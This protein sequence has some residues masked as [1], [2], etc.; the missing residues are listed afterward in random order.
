M[1][2]SIG[3][4][5][6]SSFAN[7]TTTDANGVPHS[8]SSFSEN[9]D[10]TFVETMQNNHKKRLVG[11]ME[12]NNSLLEE[13]NREIAE[14]QQQLQSQHDDAL[15]REAL[16]RAEFQN[17]RQLHADQM[18]DQQLIF[19]Q[20]REKQMEIEAELKE[21]YESSIELLKK[22]HEEQLLAIENDIQHNLQQQEIAKQDILK[23]ELTKQHSMDQRFQNSMVQMRNSHLDVIKRYKGTIKQE[24]LLNSELREEICTLTLNKNNEVMLL[25][26][27]LKDMKRKYNNLDGQYKKEMKTLHERTLSFQNDMEGV[28]RQFSG[29]LRTERNNYASEIKRLNNT[30]RTLRMNLEEKEKLYQRRI[31]SNASEVASLNA[32]LIKAQTELSN[33]RD[34]QTM[35]SLAKHEL[36]LAQSD[37]LRLTHELAASRRDANRYSN[38]IYGR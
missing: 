6:S 18:N 27:E 20:E 37:R 1:N 16:L 31:K 14:L 15:Q 29:K 32:T 19:D 22:S 11:I 28:Q 23:D 33:I 8:F 4:N 24:Q 30:I 36:H 35:S 10:S 2:G 17:L 21:Q 5:L 13:K 34:T 38:F 7:L 26:N 12:Q 9:M 3:A 25:N